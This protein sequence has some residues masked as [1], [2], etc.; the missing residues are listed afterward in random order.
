MKVGDYNS[1]VEIMIKL[2][3]NNNDFWDLAILDRVL[4]DPDISQSALAQD[5]RVAIGTV[6][7]RLQQLVENGDIQVERTRRRKLRYQL[8][9]KGRNL[10]RTLTQAYITQSFQLYREVRQQVK[11]VL[12]AITD[13]GL[14]TV[15]V[16]G[17]GDVADV[18]RLTCLEQHV[19]ITDNP[20]APAIVV[21]GLDI[22]I[23][24][25]EK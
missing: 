1:S 23:E 10:H 9:Q 5:L 18:C 11:D 6:N 3:I 12:R 19:T 4:A 24:S 21:D 14:S 7:G 25:V 2:A 17:D 16:D 20:D 8:T 15:R 22:R 13:V